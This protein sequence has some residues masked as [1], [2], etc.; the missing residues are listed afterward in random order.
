M[1]NL[2][3][4]LAIPI[5][6]RFGKH[7][8]LDCVME[9]ESQDSSVVTQVI[10]FPIRR[11]SSVTDGRSKEFSQLRKTLKEISTQEGWVQTVSDRDM[12]RLDRIH[13][14]IRTLVSSATSSCPPSRQYRS[15]SA[16]SKSRVGL[17]NSRSRVFTH[18]RHE[19]MFQTHQGC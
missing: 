11:S 8:N 10:T 9:A 12:H 2:R 16:D 19:Q 17:S 6:L 3:S 5:W 14:F 13:L 1:L 7:Q 4:S 18:L 15:R